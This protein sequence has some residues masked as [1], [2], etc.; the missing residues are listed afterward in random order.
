MKKDW[1]KGLV[2]RPVASFANFIMFLIEA[3]INVVI[4]NC[5]GAGKRGLV[6]FLR[7]LRNSYRFSILVLLEP[8]ISGVRAEKVMLQFGFDGRLK[9]DS[10]GFIGG[11]WVFWDTSIWNIEVLLIEKQLSH[12]NV[13]GYDGSS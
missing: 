6:A 12:M 8:R 11:I 2:F 10:D 5:R 13:R 1:L 7:D 9:V 4:W 3:H